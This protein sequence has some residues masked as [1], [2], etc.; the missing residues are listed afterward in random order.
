MANLPKKLNISGFEWELEEQEEEENPNLDDPTYGCTYPHAR[1]IVI[2]NKP[3]K[4]H[5][6]NEKSS[7]LFHESIHAAIF[8]GGLG[9]LIDD[10]TEEVLVTCIENSLWPLIKAGVF[11]KIK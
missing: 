11:N 7:T 1:K 4:D 2:Y 3:H 5:P 10:K 8:T 9:S 6:K